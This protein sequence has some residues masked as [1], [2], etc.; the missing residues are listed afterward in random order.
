MHLAR[1]ALAGTLSIIVG[2]SSPTLHVREA[3]ALVVCQKGKRFRLRPS[4][5]VG[6]EARVALNADMLRGMGPEELLAPLS[7]RVQAL[8][9]L[10]AV[11]TTTTTVASTTTTIS[12]LPPGRLRCS[13]LDN[14]QLTPCVAHIDCTVLSSAEIACNQACTGHGGSAGGVLSCDNNDPSC[15]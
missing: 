1:A 10:L 5:C 6:K 12:T 13:C 9:R 4:G 11:T 8:E 7:A 15:R 14:S 2:A 3:H